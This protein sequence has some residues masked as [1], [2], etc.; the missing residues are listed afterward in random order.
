M[1][2]TKALLNSVPPM[3]CRRAAA[4]SELV[5]YPRGSAAAACS[6]NLSNQD[7][8]WPQFES[9]ECRRSDC[10]SR[11]TNGKGEATQRRRLQSL[12][13]AACLLR[14]GRPKHDLVRPSR[15]E[16]ESRLGGAV[17]RQLRHVCRGL[18]DRGAN[19]AH[20]RRVARCSKFV[21]GAL[22]NRTHTHRKISK[23]R[24]V[25]VLA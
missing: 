2:R 13:V 17:C 3:K 7:Y 16:K 23:I 4:A 21:S 12:L 15:W 8:H 19:R 10:V 6:S 5:L 14:A 9:G 24:P 20:R 18:A 1:A 22:V 11:A 25:W